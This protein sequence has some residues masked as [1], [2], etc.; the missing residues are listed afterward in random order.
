MKIP[1]IISLLKK[2]ENNSIHRIYHSK[3]KW[4]F[5]TAK[6]GM[7]FKL[8]E[9]IDKSIIDFYISKCHKLNN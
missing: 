1:E 4:C 2:P 3:L 6:N 9:S 8:T 7:R 5:I